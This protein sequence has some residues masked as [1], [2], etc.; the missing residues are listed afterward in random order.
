[1]MISRSIRVA[2]NDISSFFMANS[3]V[4]MYCVFF[5]HSSLD[6]HLGCFYFLVIVNSAAANTGVHVSFWIMVFSGYMPRNGTTISYG[7]LILSFLRNLHTVLHSGCTNL[8]SHQKCRRVLLFSTP[9]PAF[10]V[11]RLWWWLFWVVWVDTSSKL[12]FAFI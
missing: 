8:H 9:F 7:N 5:I 4:Y 1:M 2:A 10:I 12:W 3:I 11:H 6:G